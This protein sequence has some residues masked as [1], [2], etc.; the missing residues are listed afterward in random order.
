MKT[1]FATVLLSI[2]SAIV[3]VFSI[4]EL[5]TKGQN[6]VGSAAPGRSSMSDAKPT[7][8]KQKVQQWVNH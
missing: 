8:P 5:C 7:A 1:V 3:A 4:S 6:T 2:L